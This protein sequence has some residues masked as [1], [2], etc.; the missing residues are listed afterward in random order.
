[1]T[2]ARAMLRRTFSAFAVPNFRLYFTGQVI[3][4][5]GSWMQRV[6]QSWLVLEMTGSGSA[7]GAVTAFQFLPLLVLAPFGGLIADRMDKRRVLYITQTLAG[8]TAATLGVLVLADV[9]Q[10]WMVFALAL[11]HGT[12]GSFDNPAR[13][14]F[15]MELVGRS[16]LTNAVGLNSVLMNTA[17]VIGPALG[18]ALIVTVGI[19]IC[20]VINSVSY[21]FFIAALLMMRSGEIERT[22]PEPR[23]RGQLR[24]ALAYVRSEPVLY[25]PL[26]M[27]GVIGLLT[28]EFEVVLPLLARFTFGGGAD[29]FGA[30]FAAMGLGSVVGGL[31]TATRG[32]QPGRAMIWLA[33]GLGGVVTMATFAPSLWVAYVALF[34]VGMCATAFFTL[35]NSVIQLNSVPE[36]RGRVIAL[37]T[38]SILGSR[39][40]GAPIVGW[41]GE[42]LGPRYAMGVGA[43]AALGV[44]IWAHR[45]LIGYE[46]RQE[47]QAAEAAS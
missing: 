4:V 25:V 40:I 5:S 39:P 42:H 16:R 2:S 36:M 30:M 28:F 35:G 1:M 21:L 15:V 29:T 10:L 7:V 44:A 11:V 3:S 24:Q 45:W 13:H 38:A 46:R 22:E 32:D 47:V 37:R 6:A 31:F 20:F 9:V 8:I 34:W 26:V 23:R 27:M 43:L 18:G 33:Y 41:I 19:G 12:V 14:A 17:R